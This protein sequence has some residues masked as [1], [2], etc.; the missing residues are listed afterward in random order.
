MMS[1]LEYANDIGKDVG[2]VLGLCSRLGIE[3]SSDSDMLSDDDIILLDNETMN[4]E[5]DD[6]SDAGVEL[7]ITDSYEDELEEVDTDVK[8]KSN[9]KNKMNSDFRGTG[10]SSQKGNSNRNNQKRNVQKKK[11]NFQKQRK[12]MYKHKEKLKSNREE[13]M[14]KFLLFEDG[15]TVSDIASN[16]KVTPAD[17][18]KKLMMMGKMVN[19]NTSIDFDTAEI[20]ALEYG[21]DI[22]RKESMDET[23]F[24]DLVIIDN[25]DDL[26]ERPPVVTIMGH[27][28]HGKTTLLDAIRKTNVAE[29]EAGGITQATYAYQITHNDKKIT[30]IDTP[31]HAAFTEMRARGA[32]ITDI[33]IIIVAADDGVMPQTVEVID[34]AKAAKVPIIVAINKIDKPSANPD[35]VMQEISNYGLIPEEWGGDVMVSKISAKTG[36]GIDDLLERILLISEL[37]GLKA[38]PN[39]YASGTV[40][41][42]KMDKSLGNVSAVLIQNGTLRLGDYLVVGNYYGKIRSLKNDRGE[43]LTFATPSMPVWIT[44]ISEIPSAG[45]KFMAFE[46]EK[47]AKSISEE[48]IL[49]AKNLNNTKRGAVSLD[50]LFGRISQ[51]EKDINIILKS[52]V[53]GSEEAVKN[54]LLKLD[55]EGIHINIIR[56][57][58]GTV[59][60]SDVVLASASDAIIIGF[61]VRP[62]SKIMEYAK[63][64]GVDIRLYNIIYKLLE[65]VES[66]MKG[67]LEPVFEERVVG[68]AV[69]RKLFKFSKV[70]T[71]AGCYVTSGCIK[72][73]AKVRLIRDGI[74]VYDGS[75]NSLAREKDQVKEVK[76]GLEC[77]ITIENFNDIKENDVME[78]YEEVEIKR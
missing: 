26:V 44:G 65:E 16:L 39:R 25:D 49:N 48:R 63:E 32:S 12:E 7:D 13:N 3:A 24:E 77:G 64:K 76:N 21:L 11:E 45:D 14:D 53:K 71:I 78:V 10:K 67:K 22:K 43:N 40:I 37:E 66:A 23:H 50:D 28:D 18:I 17:I 41:E 20:I 75:I 51:G 38:N 2:F 61:N 9:H 29:G 42:A 73:G 31:G 15:N 52:D 6:I 47:R 74:V 56:S 4:E 19:I 62:G 54:S 57:G 30:F 8:E 35:K 27:V 46:S 5:Y 34:H 72:R 59:T 36:E 68:E 69:V 33:I 55:V 1:V 70:G 58:I 60:E